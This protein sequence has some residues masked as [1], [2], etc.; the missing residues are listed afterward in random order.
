MA[1]STWKT[2][3]SILTTVLEIRIYSDLT[4]KKRSNFKSD[5][6]PTAIYFKFVKPPFTK[7]WKPNKQPLFFI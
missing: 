1:F 3:L 6:Y 2:G 5:P 4:F 7:L